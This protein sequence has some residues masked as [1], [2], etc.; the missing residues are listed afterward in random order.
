MSEFRIRIHLA[1]PN[2]KMDIVVPNLQ[3]IRSLWIESANSVYNLKIKSLKVLQNFM[4]ISTLVA[5]YVVYVWNRNA[6][7]CFSQHSINALFVFNMIS[8]EILKFIDSKPKRKS[9]W[10]FGMLC[11]IA[12]LERFVTDSKSPIKEICLRNH[13]FHNFC[14]EYLIEKVFDW[15]WIGPLIPNM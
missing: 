3:R 12:F 11:K 8:S 2:L 15:I 7:C 10:P 13:Q 1:S 14:Q 4:T 6:G 9:V 5:T